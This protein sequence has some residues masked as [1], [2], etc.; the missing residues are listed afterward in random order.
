LYIRKITLENIKTFSKFTWQLEKDEDPAG[1]HVLL[2]DNGSG[3]SSFIKCAVLALLGVDEA[4]KTRI[5]FESWIS[6]GC[7]VGSVKL[8]ICPAEGLDQWYETPP[9]LQSTVKV[10]IKITP[11]GLVPSNGVPSP[12]KHVHSFASGWFSASYG[13]FRRFSGGNNNYQALY[14]S[15]LRLSRHLSVFGE[16]VALTATLDWLKD[17]RFA[18]LEHPG[19][20]DAALLENLRIFLNQDNF[21]PNNVKM[22]SVG[23]KGVMFVDGT[24]CELGIEELSDGYRAVLS[25][26]LELIRQMVSCYHTTEIFSS[27]CTTIDFPGVVFV[28]EIDVHLHPSWQRNIGGWLTKHFPKIQFIVSTHSALVCQ[29][30]TNGSIWQ[31]PKLGEPGSE[32]RLTGVPFQRLVYG[33]IQEALSSGAFGTTIERS[34]E[35]QVM[36]EELAELNYLAGEDE[37][38]KEESNKREA[39]QAV[40]GTSMNVTR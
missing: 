30:A 24:G 9:L 31:L 10:G 20:S 25:M 39:L 17:L 16:D 21:L 6:K 12:S 8:D 40:F 2:G 19:C 38:T 7:D 36:L 5:A 22:H 11:N 4:N 32:R 37:L 29:G 28:D 26:M 33:N 3:K 34:P 18:Q 35:A 27:D 23:S 1:W 15:A 13:P 14:E